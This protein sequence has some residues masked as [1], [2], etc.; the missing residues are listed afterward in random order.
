[1]TRSYIYLCDNCVEQDKRANGY[2]GTTLQHFHSLHKFV[3]RNASAPGFLSPTPAKTYSSPLGP[4]LPPLG[5]G[6]AIGAA[7]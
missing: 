4:S 1:M 6:R 7:L 2:V 3:V 5:N